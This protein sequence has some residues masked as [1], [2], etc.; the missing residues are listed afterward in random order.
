MVPRH[1]TVVSLAYYCDVISSAAWY[2]SFC[3][4]FMFFLFVACRSQ[5]CLKYHVAQDGRYFKLALLLINGATL[6]S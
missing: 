4:K 2:D 6:T 5:I 1:I 3:K